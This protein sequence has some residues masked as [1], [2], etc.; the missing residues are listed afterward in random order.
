MR[1]DL[2][3][4]FQ[5]TDADLPPFALSKLL[6]ADRR[7]QARGPGAHDHHV[8]VH[9]FA[10]LR[11]GRSCFL[12]N[13]DSRGDSRIFLYLR[14][15]PSAYNGAMQDKDALGALN[16][17]V[18]AGADEAIG[19]TPVDRFAISVP[20]MRKSAPPPVPIPTQAFPAGPTVVTTDAVATAM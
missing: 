17:L 7:R 9:A 10:C 15:V 11:H 1:A 16:W 13:P 19:E 4:F 6:E 20:A 12:E 18:E 5:H 2:R 3:A 8:I 14:A